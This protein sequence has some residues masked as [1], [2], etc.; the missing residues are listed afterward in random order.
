VLDFA[1]HRQQVTGTP[2]AVGDLVSH[3]NVLDAG[4]PGGAWCKR[5]GNNSNP[6]T[7]SNA[8]WL[9]GRAVAKPPPAPREPPRGGLWLQYLAACGGAQ[10]LL[11]GSQREYDRR[12]P[13]ATPVALPSTA[14][15]NTLSRELETDLGQSGLRRERPRFS[16]P[17][18]VYPLGGFSSASPSQ[19]P[20]LRRAF[21]LASVLSCCAYSLCSF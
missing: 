20:G 15:G 5:P 9:R 13:P 10:R 1:N 11:G 4:D 18:V 3:R 19:M 17:V 7:N 16:E 21:A 14:P 2:D 8:S 12:R 6:A